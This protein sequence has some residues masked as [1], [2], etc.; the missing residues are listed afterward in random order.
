MYLFLHRRLG[1]QL[2]SCPRKDDFLMIANDFLPWKSR[3]LRLTE[4]DIVHAPTKRW[5]M[6]IAFGINLRSQN[7]PEKCHPSTFFL[8]LVMCWTWIRGSIFWRH[9]ALK[10]CSS[11]GIISNQIGSTGLYVHHWG[12]DLFGPSR[13]VMFLA[14]ILI[15]P[16]KLLGTHFEAGDSVPPW[17][18]G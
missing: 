11:E 4:G 7:F 13:Y 10:G 6:C 2:V 1:M 3:Q 18:R 5:C 17:R 9:P 14:V 12:G 16:R 15:L 8:S